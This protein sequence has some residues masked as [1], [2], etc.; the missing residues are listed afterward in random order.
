GKTTTAPAATPGS[1]TATGAA[2][3]LIPVA[4][5]INSFDRSRQPSRPRQRLVRSPAGARPAEFYRPFNNPLMNIPPA[6]E[7]PGG[8]AGSTP[9]RASASPTEAAIDR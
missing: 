1:A 2:A 9:Y 7:W 8:G 5:R 6:K 3:W 4:T